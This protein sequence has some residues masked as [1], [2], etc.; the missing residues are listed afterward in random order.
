MENRPK[1]TYSLHT[2]LLPSLC[3]PE[4]RGTER[5]GLEAEAWSSTPAWLQAVLD[6]V[7]LPATLHVNSTNSG[8]VPCCGI[9]IA[10]WLYHGPLYC[11][12]GAE[13]L[14]GSQ[15]RLHFKHC[16][17]NVLASLFH[18]HTKPI[19]QRWIPVFN[20]FS[21]ISKKLDNGL[22]YCFPPVVDSRALLWLGTISCLI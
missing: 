22:N 20:C 14:L 15:H 10:I 6:A 12:S 7:L 3:S 16:H 13:R 21:C 17:T 5:G 8:K 19:G 18:R 9:L 1:T 11:I 2:S 4:N